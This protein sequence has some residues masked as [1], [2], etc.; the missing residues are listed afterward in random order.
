MDYKIEKGHIGVWII[1]G[2][3]MKGCEWNGD[4]L[5]SHGVGEE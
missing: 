3:R 5:D 1:R 4:N 2:V